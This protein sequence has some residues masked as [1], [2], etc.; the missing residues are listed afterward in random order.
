[1]TKL[2]YNVHYTNLDSLSANDI[3][4]NVTEINC[5]MNKIKALP[6]LVRFTKLLT[7]RCES[8][9]LTH[10]PELPPNLENIYCKNNKIQSLPVM[11]S[12]ILIFSAGN[13]SISSTQLEYPISIEKL[14]LQENKIIGPITFVNELPNLIALQLS[15]NQ[16]TE[17]TNLSNMKSIEVLSFESNDLRVVPKLPLTLRFLGLNNNKLT[18]LPEIHLL[19]NLK[20]L[21][22]SNNQIQ[23]IPAL[24]RNIDT[25]TVHDNDISELPVLEHFEKLQIIKFD[26]N[27]ISVLPNLPSSIKYISGSNNP[28]KEI[29]YL[30]SELAYLE[31]QKIDGKQISRNSVKHVYDFYSYYYNSP[32]VQ[33]E[34]SIDD[35]ILH[36]LEDYQNEP[37]PLLG[38]I[39]FLTEPIP[40]PS[41]VYIRTLPRPKEMFDIA[42]GMMPMT[43]KLDNEL[44]IFLVDK[45]VL[46]TIYPLQQLI[47]SYSDRS[48]I[49]VSC[50]KSSMLSFTDDNV[51][52][53][54]FKLMLMQPF[55]I[56]IEEMKGLLTST[57]RQWSLVKSNVEKEFTGSIGSVRWRNGVNIL[58]EI[59]DVVS[60]HHCQAA[61][62]L[63]VYNLKPIKFSA[64]R[65]LRHFTYRTIRRKPSF[66]TA[67]KSMKSRKSL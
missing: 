42:N 14:D 43:N 21:Q 61:T 25:L 33:M 58:G 30:T 41:D 26:N 29:P 52:E 28:I 7:L 32:S 55:L 5:N 34:V 57:H 11:P 62:N 67:R 64:R 4:E 15:R 6:S 38:D 40:L 12:S 27:R 54:F 19:S 49:F 2:V 53:V 3:D 31:L 50:K 18:A 35:S 10:L 46:P 59:D 36:A 24:P 23:V 47:N 8:N 1:M 60:R 22:V 17:V 16:I 63:T 65:T 9:L 66:K 44:V 39:P 48:S 51:D 56:P 45:Q 13:N 37:P 20:Y